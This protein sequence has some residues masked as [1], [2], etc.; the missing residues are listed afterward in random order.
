MQNNEWHPR[1]RCKRCWYH[2]PV[3][4]EWE[5]CPRCDWLD[6]PDVAVMRLEETGEEAFGCPVKVWVIKSTQ[7]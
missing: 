6:N 2:F 1:Y 5:G 3:L 4:S 7:S